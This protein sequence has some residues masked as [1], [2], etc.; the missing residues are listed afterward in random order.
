[1]KLVE[2]RIAQNHGK[3]KDFYKKWSRII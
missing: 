2:K 3:L 1:M